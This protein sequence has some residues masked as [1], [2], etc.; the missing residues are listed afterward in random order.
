GGLTRTVQVEGIESQSAAAEAGLRRGDALVRVGGVPI[1]CSFDVDRALLGRN[2]GDAVPGIYRRAGQ[3]QTVS[4][5]LRKSSGNHGDAIDLVWRK[6]G[7]Q[8]TAVGRDA[9][10]QYNSQLNGGLQVTT[11]AANGL[12]ERAGIR[13]GDILVGLHQWETLTCD[14]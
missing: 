8:L 14:N 2:P 4:L 13:K 5:T 1:L 7:L 3:E 6:L 10:T 9:V 12:A 11:V